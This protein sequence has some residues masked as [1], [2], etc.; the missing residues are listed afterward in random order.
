MGD[1]Q[2][3]IRVANDGALKGELPASPIISSVTLFNHINVF[4]LNFSSFRV[5]LESRSTQISRSCIVE[6]LVRNLRLDR[7]NQCILPTI[8]RGTM[9]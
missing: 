1:W 5:D 9:R 8:S 6:A 3:A 4:K 2:S 7:S